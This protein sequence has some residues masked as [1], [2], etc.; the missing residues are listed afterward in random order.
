M[1]RLIIRKIITIANSL[2]ECKRAPA[3]P[4]F[5]GPNPRIKTT[6]L[7]TQISETADFHPNPTT[8]RPTLPPVD[9]S[10]DWVPNRE[11][12]TF[13]RSTDRS[14]ELQLV[15]VVH[16]RSTGPFDRRTCSAAAA[17]FLLLSPL[18]FRRRLHWR[19]PRRPLGN[20]CQLP[21]Q[22]SLFP[23]Y[24]WTKIN[25]HNYPSLGPK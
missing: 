5:S 2:F 10:V 4:F 13:S 12:G 9:R 16:V 8:G 6:A 25:V 21:L 14:T 24:Q 22:Y 18:P 3:N 19:S 17:I 1:E 7:N 15:H 23:T 11:L 20:P